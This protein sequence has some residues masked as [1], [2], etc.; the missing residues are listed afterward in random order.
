MGTQIWARLLI[1]AFA[2]TPVA[3][4]ALPGEADAVL[5]HCGEPTARSQDTS[6]VTGLAERNLTY[7]D[8]TLHFQ[9][10]QGGWSFTT[11]W[12]KHLPIS[13]TALQQRMP[14]FRDAMEEVAAVPPQTVDPSIAAQSTVPQA[15]STTFGPSFLWLMGLLVVSILLFMAIPARKR[16]RARK[17]MVLEDRPYRKPRII[18]VPFLRRKRVVPKPD[19]LKPTDL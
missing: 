8:V 14:C 3:A 2:L 4:H 1:V 11:G 16:V 12:H 5:R 9:P 17:E 13:R 15:S 18:G 6:E 7:N 10:M 19:D